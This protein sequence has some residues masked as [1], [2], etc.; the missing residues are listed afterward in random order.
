MNKI[1]RI[2]LLASLGVGCEGDFFLAATFGAQAGAQVGVFPV[3]SIC[4]VSPVTA[5]TFRQGFPVSV[6]T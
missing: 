6:V 2:H 5:A 4:L 1:F 3:D